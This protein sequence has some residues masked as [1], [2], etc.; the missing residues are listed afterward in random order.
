MEKVAYEIVK[1]GY[2]D[3]DYEKI[4]TLFPN[5]DYYYK[6]DTPIPFYIVM[7]EWLDNYS[8]ILAENSFITEGNDYCR[9]VISFYFR[10]DFG[11]MNM[12]FHALNTNKCDYKINY[13]YAFEC[14]RDFATNQCFTTIFGTDK[15]A[16]ALDDF[17]LIK[18]WIKVYLFH[19]EIHTK[20]SR[21]EELAYHAIQV[22]NITN[23]LGHL[24]RY[25]SIDITQH[26]IKNIIFIKRKLYSDLNCV[27][28]NWS[29]FEAIK[30]KLQNR[31]EDSDYIINNYNSIFKDTSFAYHVKKIKPTFYNTV[32][33]NRFLCQTISNYQ[34]YVHF[35]NG[36]LF[37][38]NLFDTVYDFLENNF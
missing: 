17:I 28:D 33:I 21:L 7:I 19:E 37:I 32:M 6:V 18:K 36:D 27:I 25:S 12:A 35:K 22:N 20:P 23:P 31:F 15:N 13:S 29:I 14:E 10:V 8:D 24:S 2:Y 9:V 4:E 3:F 11:K 16:N 34:K 5:Y 1:I 38:L 30:Y 26:Y